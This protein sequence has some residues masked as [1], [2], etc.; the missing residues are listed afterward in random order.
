MPFALGCA[1]SPA[2]PHIFVRNRRSRLYW[3]RADTP[4][5]RR[6]RL[7]FASFFSCVTW[8]ASVIQL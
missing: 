8:A 4:E 3:L 7:E 1:L 2:S 5:A 6:P